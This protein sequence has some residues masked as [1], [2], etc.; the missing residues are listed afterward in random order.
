MNAFGIT[1][2]PDEVFQANAWNGTRD[3]RVDG[4]SHPAT[5]RSRI[6]PVFV[7]DVL[8]CVARHRLDAERLLELMV[9]KYAP[10]AKK[11][12]DWL[13]QNVPEGLTVFNFSPITAAAGRK[14]TTAWNG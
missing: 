14:P 11:L 13:E 3:R 10:S 6:E 5:F 12:A 8:P 1:S 2:Y 7:A 4:R 9:S